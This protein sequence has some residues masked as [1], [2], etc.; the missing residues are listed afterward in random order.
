MELNELRNK[1]D[2]IDDQLASLYDRR[3]KLIK[4]VGKEKAKTNRYV[5][6]LNREN[7]IIRRVTKAVDEDVRVYCKQVFETLFETS[8]AYQARFVRI[9]SGIAEQIRSTLE[10][11]LKAF[12]DYATVACQG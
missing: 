11:G 8:R 5:Q 3:M 7:A 4:E 2:D 6:D 1:I 12:P 10:S 9:P